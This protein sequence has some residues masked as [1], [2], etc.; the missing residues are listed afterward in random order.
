MLGWIG[1]SAT[2][3]WWIVIASAVTLF[4]ALIATPLVVIRI[5]A[6]YFTH[7]RRSGADWPRR[8]PRLRL[9]WVIAKNLL[10][11]AFLVLGSLMLILPGQGL[12]TLLIAIALLDFPG[13]FRFQRWVITR[14]GV[15]QSINWMRKKAGRGPLVLSR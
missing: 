14:R 5:P 3:G 15:I 4:A 1:L 6:D 9:I 11:C 8:R 7:P 12:L 10:G 2:A 13:K